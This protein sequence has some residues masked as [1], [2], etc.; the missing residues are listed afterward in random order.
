M[1]RWSQDSKQSL[2]FLAAAR[3]YLPPYLQAPVDWE[4]QYMECLHQAEFQLALELLERI[5]DTH[6]GYVDEIQFWKELYFAAQHMALPEHALR[7]EAKLQRV[8]SGSQS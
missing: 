5:G 8:V 6:S 2:R 3:Y 1:R 4:E 7:Y